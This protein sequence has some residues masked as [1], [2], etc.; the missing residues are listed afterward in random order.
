MQ[1]SCARA[2]QSLFEVA[3]QLHWVGCWHVQHL[4][5]WLPPV[6]SKDTR[7]HMEEHE[8]NFSAISGFVISQILAITVYAVACVYSIYAGMEYCLLN[9]LGKFS[10]Y[11]SKWRTAN[12]KTQ[13]SL[14]AMIGSFIT[15]LNWKEHAFNTGKCHFIYQMCVE[16]KWT[17]CCKN[18]C[19]GHYSA[20]NGSWNNS[21]LISASIKSLK[22]SE[23]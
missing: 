2:L 16:L 21:F 14:S 7:L 5:Q 18:E 15:L 10:S 23:Y 8:I 4:H 20:W 11:K 6:R 1:P 22:K 13:D 19:R 12:W 3:L 17:L 9:D